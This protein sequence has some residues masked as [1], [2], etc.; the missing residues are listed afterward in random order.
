M[1]SI[2]GAADVSETEETQIIPRHI[3]FI[4]DGNGRWAKKNRKNTAQGH[5]QGANQ[6][7]KIL[8]YAFDLGIEAV[9]LY[10][11]SSENW[12]R[13]ETEISALFQL[14]RYFFKKKLPKLMQKNSRVVVIGDKSRF[15]SEINSIL[16]E[17]ESASQANTG[18]LIQIALNY[19]G[20]NEIVRACKKI[21][22]CSQSQKELVETLDESTFAE[23]LDTKHAKEPDLLI[24]TGGDFRISNFLLW[25]IAYSELYFSDK[26]WPEFET[27]DLDMAIKS[28]AQRERR[29]GGR[30]Q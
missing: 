2:S 23:F 7:E 15:S 4:L 29:F 22:A 19:G 6:V 10:A 25:Q 26:L 16:D 28:F 21:I 17:T 11:F 3:A 13:S 1:A 12:K 30:P 20:R 14:L 27:H 18:P 8:D 9:T 24:R 5:R